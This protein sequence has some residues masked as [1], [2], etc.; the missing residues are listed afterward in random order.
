M[1]DRAARPEGSRL[2]LAHT[3]A[4]VQALNDGIRAGLKERGELQ[5]EAPFEA[6]AGARTFAAGDRVVFLENSR[7]LGV[8]NGTLG[9]VL[10]ARDGR[11]TARLDEGGRA[12]TIAAIGYDAVDHGY[13]TTIHK[14]QGITVDRAFV[15]GSGSMDR[16]M[17]YVALTRHRDGVQLYAGREEF[18]DFAALSS[19]L[20]RGGVKETTLDYARRRGLEAEGREPARDGGVRTAAERPL[21]WP[22]AAME[23][24]SGPEAQETPA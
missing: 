17:T 12:V 16:H 14:A 23:R 19:R 3:R 13:A 15:V 7:E 9:T 2:A 22:L 8:K 20:S 24:G 6:R 18:R 4:D 11:L 21:R 1:R 10:E 5:D